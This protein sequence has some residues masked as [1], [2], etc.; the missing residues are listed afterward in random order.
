MVVKIWSFMFSL[1]NYSCGFLLYAH[2]HLFWETEGEPGVKL[3]PEKK[4]N[5]VFFNFKNSN[6][7]AAMPIFQKPTW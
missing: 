7:N 6:N 1:P 4:T 3:V 2:S 5:I